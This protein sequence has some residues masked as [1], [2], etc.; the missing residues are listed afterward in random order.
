MA[1]KGDI[2]RVAHSESLYQLCRSQ[3]EQVHGDV[4]VLQSRWYEETHI[5]GGT[6]F[7]TTPL[8]PPSVGR[9]VLP[10]L[11]HHYLEN[12]TGETIPLPVFVVLPLCRKSTFVF[13]NHIE[14]SGKL[15]ITAT[16]RLIGKQSICGWCD[17]STDSIYFN[18]MS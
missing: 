4:F 16:V 11:F 17:V 5:N 9:L 15:T 1:R 8:P 6:D 14:P 12:M 18:M 3:T 2:I 7:D 10:Q 13:V